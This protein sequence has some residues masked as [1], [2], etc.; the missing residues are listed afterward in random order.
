MPKHSK[1]R[2]GSLQFWPRKRGKK[3]LPRVNWDGIDSD[4][5]KGIIGYKVGMASA[6]LKDNT[7]DSRSNGKNIIIPSTI[8]EVP[9]MKIFSVRFYKN[10][11][12]KT[13]IINS[14]LDKELKKIVKIGK[15]GKSDLDK[16]ED[17]DDIRVIIYSQVKN[18]KIKKNPDITEIGL[19]GGKEEKLKWVK[20]N[21][22]KE[23]SVS[24][25]FNDNELLD[26]RGL[27]K[28]KGIQGPVKRFGI[29]LRTHKSEKGRRKVGS[30]GPW[31]PARVTFRVPMAGQL[32]MFTRN[33]Y[34]NH[35]IKI[36][37]IEDKNINPEEGWKHYG[38][39]NTEYIIVKGSVQGPKKRQLLLT[40]PLRKSKKRDKQNYEF[41]ELK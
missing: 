6:L 37:K 21:L 27:T 16:I 2:A 31:H 23:I 22:D 40:K 8:L 33:K 35:I 29:K 7:P 38:K 25:I 28:G 36:G 24:D 5:L 32:G 26:V 34:N 41:L 13:E 11:E 9:K 14:N 19:G 1:P 10:G 18:T 39:I 30:I 4:S 15:G 12:V 3:F 17:Y 20:E